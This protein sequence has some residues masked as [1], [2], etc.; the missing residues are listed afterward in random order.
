MTEMTN[1]TLTPA[2][3]H[4]EWELKYSDKNGM[5]CNNQT[6]ER[7]VEVSK[8]RVGNKTTWSAS[9]MKYGGHVKDHDGL[10][11]K[12]AFELAHTLMNTQASSKQ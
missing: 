11:K 9:Y 3:Q 4:A 6:L 2:E 7:I 8:H 5:Q 10:N 1:F 12:K